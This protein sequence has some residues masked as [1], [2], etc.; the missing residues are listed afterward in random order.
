MY[1]ICLYRL[2]CHFDYRVEVN[3]IPLLLLLVS[4]YSTTFGIYFIV[5]WPSFGWKTFLIAANILRGQMPP[6]LSP[7]EARMNANILYSLSCRFDH[8]VSVSDKGLLS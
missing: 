7:N 1:A 4:H 5:V 8:C 3:I 2:S 6:F